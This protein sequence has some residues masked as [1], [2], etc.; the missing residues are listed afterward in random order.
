MAVA[1]CASVMTAVTVTVCPLTVN[2]PLS[3]R[4]PADWGLPVAMSVWARKIAVPG[5]PTVISVPGLSVTV[6]G[7]F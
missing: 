6:G 2:V 7:L 1:I 3:P 4:T 5:S